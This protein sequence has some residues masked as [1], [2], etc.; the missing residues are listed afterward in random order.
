MQYISICL[1]LNY[2]ENELKISTLEKAIKQSIRKRIYIALSVVFI[3]PLLLLGYAYYS[4]VDLVKAEVNIQMQQLS[5]NIMGQY[6]VDNF[7]AISLNVLSFNKSHKTYQVMWVK[8]SNNNVTTSSFNWGV[9]YF[10]AKYPISSDVGGQTISA[11]QLLVKGKLTL[12]ICKKIISILVLAV[13]ICVFALLLYLLLMPLAND[14]PERLIMQ[15]M[16][17]L[18]TL[19]RHEGN[20]NNTPAQSLDYEEFQQIEQQI[21]QLLE[22]VKQRESDLAFISIS[23]K[24][25]HDVKSPL[26]TALS[27][28]QRLYNNS[29]NDDLV[30]RMHKALQNI[31]SQLS[32]LHTGVEKRWSLDHE[33]NELPCYVLFKSCIQEIVADKIIEQNNNVEV[34]I[35]ANELDDYV[36]CNVAPYVFSNHI[37]NLLNNAYEAVV[38]NVS[39]AVIQISLFEDKENHKLIC[40]V[41]DNGCGMSEEFLIKAM[42]GGCTTKLHGSGIGLSSA[43]EYF[44]EH[45]GN[46][47][48]SSSEN[49]G[50]TVRIELLKSKPPTWFTKDIIQ[51]DSVVILDDDHEIHALLHDTFYDISEVHYFTQVKQFKQWWSSNHIQNDVTYFIDN[52]I[53]CRDKLGVELIDE[54]KI[55]HQAYLIT[56]DYDDSELQQKVT[57]MGIK[58]IPKQLLKIILKE[59]L[60]NG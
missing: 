27:C 10:S 46:I 15:P 41:C 5:E 12:F 2:L 45:G 49:V 48:I 6:L 16:S 26:K 14:I 20:V 22:V 28:N 7:E 8:P 53:E 3:I 13:I 55:N 33:N 50:T 57:S 38:K 47:I 44:I 32:R 18:L 54:Y 52:R 39:D 31:R 9:I 60:Y 19:M 43:K 34:L 29:I 21:R 17:S 58:M 37:S 30:R 42:A 25:I 1:E 36:W 24:V 40:E 35:I 59:S 51:S 56:D 23:R 4:V 11:G